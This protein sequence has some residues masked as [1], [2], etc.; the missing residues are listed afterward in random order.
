MITFNKDKDNQTY[1]VQAAHLL[2][3]AKAKWFESQKREGKDFEA[4]K[5][6]GENIINKEG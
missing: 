4:G 3:L 1:S 5:K 2:L 6:D